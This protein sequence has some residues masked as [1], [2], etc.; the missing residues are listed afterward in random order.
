MTNIAMVKITMLLSSV[1]HLFLRAIFHGELLNN[2]IF[3][4]GYTVGF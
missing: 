3:F 1:N 4:S 2:Q